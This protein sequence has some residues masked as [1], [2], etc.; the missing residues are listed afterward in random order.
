MP[1]TNSSHKVLNSLLVGVDDAN[2][3]LI[4]AVLPDNA[5]LS[6]VSSV[7]EAL[8][9]LLLPQ[10]TDT[11]VIL[12]GSS[13]HAGEACQQLRQDNRARLIPVI[14]ILSD[15]A[16]RQAAL[17]AGVNDYLLQPISFAEVRARLLP[18]LNRY[19]IN[20]FSFL[21]GALAYVRDGIPF[22]QALVENP[23]ILTAALGAVSTS[24]YLWDPERNELNF[25]KQ[26]QPPLKNNLL[27]EVLAGN[28]HSLQIVSAA[29]STTDTGVYLSLPLPGENHL[30][31]LLLVEYTQP[32]LF[33]PGQQ[34]M[35]TMMGETIG[36]LIE[37]SYLQEEAQMY[38]TQT[39]FLVMLAKVLAEQSDLKEMLLLALEHTVSLLNTSG[40]DI[41]LLSP[42][43]KWLEQASSLSARLSLHA[44]YR[45]PANKGIVGWAAQQRTVMRLTSIEDF[46]QFDPEFDGVLL[47]NGRFLLAVPLYHHKPIGVVI[48]YRAREPFSDQDSILLEGIA[49]LL[50]STI[51]GAIQVNE[52]RDY[53]EQQRILYEM[54][55]QLAT[56]LDLQTTL[57]RAL[58]WAVRLCNVE[59]GL[60]WLVDESQEILRLAA[61]HGIAEVM[62]K[63]A[64]MLF[65]PCIVGL[66]VADKQAM[67]SNVCRYKPNSD[68]V[69]TQRLGI[70]TNNIMAVPIL[71]RSVAIGSI[72]LVNKIGSDFN[73][74]D[75]TLLS[76]AAEMVAVAISNARL[77]TK[78]ITLIDERERLFKQ[79]IQTERQAVVGRLTNSLAHEINNPMQTIKGAMHLALEELDD[80]VALREYIDIS[81]EQ[82]NRVVQLVQRMRQVYRPQSNKSETINLN[83]LL[84]EAIAV[85][86]KEMKRQSVRLHMDLATDLPDIWTATN[87]LYLVI[88]NVSLNLCEMMGKVG[89]GDLVIRSYAV[90]PVIRI[91]LATA[92]PLNTLF[93]LHKILDGETP[94]A[95][96]L[97]FSFSIDI[98]SAL[99]GT[100][101][102]LEQGE[103]VIFRIE[104]PCT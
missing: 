45:I 91:E 31:G 44:P 95:I 47:E 72:N 6:S 25:P 71:Y 77:Y 86:R 4:T 85:S 53:G 26:T 27:Q 87:Q 28:G 70:V 34:Q 13:Q 24:L 49:G 101:Q 3:Q 90:P 97:G 63:K 81:I 54:S 40:G 39:A 66:S 15:P 58:G 32:P 42:D 79:A 41:W 37:V 20:Q 46:P 10:A 5:V 61:E 38:A 17:E 50:A 76:T 82:I 84:Q 92:V 98:I 94:Q 75:L 93:N 21:Q 57:N 51:T 89:G 8:A 12:L 16:Q 74:A 103:Q 19:T 104:L 83:H 80:P 30:M 36:H 68:C 18:Y 78:T 67:M 52:L 100:L 2:T 22:V 99:G 69:L 29:Q 56:G 33:S 48:I 65:K 88:L 35:M 7:A 73:Q 96:G 64:T 59:I 14:A 1:S 102:L 43:G 23:G 55:Q 11:A 9:A 60:L 62:D